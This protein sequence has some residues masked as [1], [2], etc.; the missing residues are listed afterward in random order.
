MDLLDRWNSPDPQ[1]ASARNDMSIQVCA[2]LRAAF[3]AT[4]RIARRRVSAVGE[5]RRFAGDPAG[6]M[7]G[8]IL[9]A[10][11]LAV[12]S[13]NAYSPGAI[14]GSLL[15]SVAVFWLAHAYTDTLGGVISDGPE[16]SV[17]F[18][19]GLRKE[20][21]IVESARSGGGSA[22]LRG[23]RRAAIDIGLRSTDHSQ[24]RADR[25][26]LP[27]RSPRWSDR[28]A[29][30]HRLRHRRFARACPR[31]PEVPYPLTRWNRGG[32]LGAPVA[33]YRE[34]ATSPA[35]PRAAAF[36]AAL[37]ATAPPCGG[38]G[39]K[40]DPPRSWVARGPGVNVD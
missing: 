21:P 4:G 8:T 10:G 14:V 35:G 23:Y 33:A 39:G 12:E 32:G 17:S 40:A 3:T 2:W 31:R 30:R 24:P 27:C 22:G 1:R 29:P 20:W 9:V 37:S 34:G 28:A 26:G 11:Q 25:L 5:E 38:E 19:R 7:Y 13:T 16:K 36:H 18:L 6:A 15:A